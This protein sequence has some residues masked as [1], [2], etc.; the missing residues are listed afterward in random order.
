M[1]LF[2][3][4]SSASSSSS[5]SFCCLDLVLCGGSGM[6]GRGEWICPGGGFLWFL[7][8]ALS[9]SAGSNEEAANY[10]L[11]FGTVGPLHARFHF[12]SHFVASDNEF[13]RQRQDVRFIGASHLADFLC[14]LVPTPTDWPLHH[15]IDGRHWSVSTSCRRRFAIPSIIPFKLMAFVSHRP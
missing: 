12:E 14:R 4:S 10:Q 5:S 6:G 11:T 9:R 8:V 13:Q 3:W 2:A 1:K 7:V 15:R